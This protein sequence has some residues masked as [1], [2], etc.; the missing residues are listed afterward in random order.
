MMQTCNSTKYEFFHRCFS[1][2]MLKLWTNLY[3]LLEIE[4][5]YVIEHAIMAAS[6]KFTSD[7]AAHC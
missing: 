7:R 2:S 5:T 3:D 1:R 6:K 4:K